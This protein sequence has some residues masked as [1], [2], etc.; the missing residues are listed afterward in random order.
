[1]DL[2]QQL[3]LWEKECV[4][5]RNLLQSR[6]AET[7]ERI[8]ALT[9][10][11]SRMIEATCFDKEDAD[12][13]SSAELEEGEVHQRLLVALEENE[14][15]AAASARVLKEFATTLS[16]RSSFLENHT[17]LLESHPKLLASLAKKQVKLENFLASSVS[18]R[19]G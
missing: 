5:Q 18:K 3:S 10:L 4:A 6:I 19:L 14:S 16:T 13:V 15:K 9:T 1:M 12:L 2:S 17:R 8:S 11:K 7:T